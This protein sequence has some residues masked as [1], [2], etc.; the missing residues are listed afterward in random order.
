VMP[1]VHPL[2]PSRAYASGPEAN[3]RP[4]RMTTAGHFF[5]P[6]ERV[7]WRNPQAKQAAQEAVFSGAD[8]SLAQVFSDLPAGPCGE[9]R[10]PPSSKRSVIL[11]R[12]VRR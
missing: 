1:G 8:R 12:A 11:R 10:H 9:A 4:E 5:R 2:R 3:Y 7:R 6:S